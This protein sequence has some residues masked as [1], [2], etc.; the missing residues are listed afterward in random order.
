MC[1]RQFKWVLM[2]RKLAKEAYP[3]RVWSLG[4]I[5]KGWVRWVWGCWSS[6]RKEA[7]MMVKMMLMATMRSSHMW[8]FALWQGG[9]EEKCE[10][11]EE[12]KKKR[13]E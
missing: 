9:L 7:T 5:N 11:R 3:T 1:H 6:K 4:K 12:K 8:R 10:G 2:G 13:G